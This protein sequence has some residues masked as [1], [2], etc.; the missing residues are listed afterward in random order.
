MRKVRTTRCLFYMGKIVFISLSRARYRISI[1]Q[2]SFDWFFSLVRQIAVLY[3]LFVNKSNIEYRAVIKFF[4]RKGLRSTEITEELT[5]VYGVSAP[6]Y[7]TVA[8]WVAEF[9]DPA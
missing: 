2:F 4:P 3:R 9:N 5:D 8:N 6:S 7:C 1:Y